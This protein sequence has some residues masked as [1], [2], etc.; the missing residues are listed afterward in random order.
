[1]EFLW[2]AALEFIGC[3]PF[4]LVAIGVGAL[5]FYGIRAEKKRKEA[6]AQIASD[7]GLIYYEQGHDSLQQALESFELFNTGRSRRITNMIYGDT[8]SEQVGVFD[9][10]YRTGSGKNS[11]TH[12]QTVVFIQSPQL[13]L[14]GFSMS[15]ENF[16]HRIATAF[17]Y[18]DINFD[19]HPLFSK[20]FLL[21][22]ADEEA[23]RRTFKPSLLEFFEARKGV[24]VEGN[25]NRLIFFRAG[26]RIKPADF[27]ELMNEGLQVYRQ[28]L[29]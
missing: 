24:S 11:S 7:L 20:A 4:I 22:G 26:H 10:T 16:L 13:E 12:N 23:V 21:R 17:G 29:A 14:T 1:M 6:V 28:F 18:T 25:G 19:T 2:V 9:Y 3:L 27:V 15:P 5:I 8:E